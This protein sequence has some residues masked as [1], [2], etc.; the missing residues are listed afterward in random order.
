VF[1]VAAKRAAAGAAGAKC[2]RDLLA[3][4]DDPKRPSLDVLQTNSSGIFSEGL[5]SV[6]PPGFRWHGDQGYKSLPRAP[7]IVIPGIGAS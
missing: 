6:G 4:D 2:A 1:A 7:G 5:T 3:D